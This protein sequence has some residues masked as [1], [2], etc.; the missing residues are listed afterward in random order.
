MEGLCRCVRNM[1]ACWGVNGLCES[2][3]NGRAVSVCEEYDSV[4]GCKWAM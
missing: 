3:W 4:L 1:T 2:V